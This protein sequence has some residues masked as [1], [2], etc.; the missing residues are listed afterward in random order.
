MPQA[1]GST[2]SGW[3]TAT[4]AAADTIAENERMCPTRKIMNGPSRQPP[5]KPT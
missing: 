2:A 1:I 4:A 5:T 3:A